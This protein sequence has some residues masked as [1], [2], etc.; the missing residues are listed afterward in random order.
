MA[1]IGEDSLRYPGWR[2]VLAAHLGT[3]VSF[4]S[5][6]V[7][8]FGV[9]LKPV[10]AEF[11]WSREEISRGFAVAAMTVAVASPFLGHA[12]D[13]WGP[14]RVVLPCFAA[15]AA[16]LFLLGR[17]GGRLAEFYAA[18][19]LIG[20]AGNGTT[21]MGY[22]GAVASW[23]TRRR[24][25]ALACVMAGV[26]IGSLAHPVIAERLI[27]G[28]GW[29]SAYVVLAATVLLIGIPPSAL[30]LRRRESPRGQR[31]RGGMGVREPLAR[32]EFWLLVAVLFLGSLAVNGTL[33]HM[34]AHLT[35]RGMTA[36]EAAL[37]TGILGVANL[38]GRL[39]TGWLLDRYFGP[40][41]SALL[42]V[43]MAAGFLVLLGARTAPAAALAAVLI[44]VGLGGEADVTPYLLSRY[45]GLSSFSTLYGVTWTFYALAGGIG[46]VLFGRAFDSSGGY[47]A[48][49]RAAAGLTL[50]AAALMFGLRR[51]P[52]ASGLS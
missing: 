34:A 14:R 19:F 22:G 24:G 27:A 7:F 31:R 1:S 8:T 38:F 26:G 16:G 15:F 40:R 46:P 28:Y 6:F 18:C 37:A 43:S 35:D 45:F 50:A 32:C 12:L 10:A 3:M 49:L 21:Q 33:T 2:A 36:A 42:L 11:G 51:Y 48:V 5:L 25:L 41:L 13:R 47:D 52:P 17:I 39:M 30:W 9:F 44:G 4:G 23:F 20:A 29:R